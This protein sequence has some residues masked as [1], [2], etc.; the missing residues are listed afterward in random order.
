MLAALSLYPPSMYVSDFQTDRQTEHGTATEMLPRLID[1]NEKGALSLA[2]F[3]FWNSVLASS[4]TQS[5]LLFIHSFIR[6]AKE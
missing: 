2:F 1:E 4:Y 3:L 5:L 6:S